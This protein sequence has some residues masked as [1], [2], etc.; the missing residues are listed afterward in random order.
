MRVNRLTCEFL[1]NPIAIDAKQPRLGWILTSEPKSHE[2]NKAQSAYKVLVASTIE[3]LT[4]EKGDLWDSGKVESAD[5]CHVEY[6]GQD[7]RSRMKCYWKVKVWDEKGAETGWS[8]A[9]CWIMGVL[10]ESDWTETSKWIGAHESFTFEERFPITTE[11]AEVPEAFRAAARRLHPSGEGPENPHAMALYLRKEFMLNQ[12]PTKIEQ[13]IVRIAGLG[14]YELSL[15]GAKV[16]DHVLDPGA[17]DYTKHVFYIAYDVTQ[18]LQKGNNCIGVTLG[19]GWYFV[20]TPDLFGYEK[21]PW[22]APPKCRL[23]LEIISQEGKRQILGTDETWEC[24]EEG[25]IRFN[26]IR[27]GEVYDARKDLGA[28]DTPSGIAQKGKPWENVRIVSKPQG[29][30]RVQMCPPIKVERAI[31]PSKHVEPESGI[32]VYHFPENVAGWVQIKVNGQSGQT[33][34]L[35]LNEK[36][37]EDGLVDIFTHSGHTFGRFQTCEYICKGGGTETWHPRFCYQGFQFVQVEGAKLDEIVDIEAQVVHTA[38]TR[39]GHFTCSNSLINQIDEIS[40]RTFLNGFHSY[41]EDCPQREKAGWTED[42]TLSAQGSMYNFDCLGIYEKWARDLLDA[43]EGNGQ[44]PDIVPCPGWGRPSHSHNA[45]DVGNM[46]DPWWGGAI[47]HLPWTIY[48]HYGD[49][50]LLRDC[51]PAMK[52]YVKFLDST[53]KG[54]K[55]IRWKTLLGDWLEVGAGSSANRTPKE[56]TATQAFY[57]YTSII[58]KAAAILGAKESEKEFTVLAEKIAASCNKQFLDNNTGLYCED[59]QSAPAISLF[60][61]LAP[62]QL[63][64]KIFDQLVQN[65]ESKWK[66]HLSTGIVGSYF[67]YQA[68]S[69]EG[70]PEIAYDAIVAKGFPGFEHMLNFH[71]NKQ[72]PTTTLWEDWPGLSSLCHPVQGCVVSYFY[73]FLAGIRPEIEQPGFKRFEI[74]PNIVRDLSEAAA[75]VESLYGTIRSEWKRENNTLHL[76]VEVPLNTSALVI[77]PGSDPSAVQEESNP[78][79]NCAGVSQI[80]VIK[81]TIRFNA[82][83]GVYDFCIPFNNILVKKISKKVKRT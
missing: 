24:S 29:E 78:L 35:K 52:R 28:W 82:G 22:A 72:A 38:V 17:T 19:G 37:L 73:E 44:V 66:G 40:R 43:Q 53:T 56:L 60:T 48:R 67:L 64:A 61:G 80:E 4:A 11:I 13:A 65:V 18:N 54:D 55:I 14:Y 39:A 81:N 25:P 69:R 42:G 77:L 26:C 75:R 83:S 15:N 76:N 58:A 71:S 33:I 63:R 9:A 70:T 31:K 74:A 45:P 20:G 10:A 50:A 23:E 36:L 47:V 30:L 1:V 79:A 12:S 8:E 59:S 57:Y 51:F 7:L 34:T 16:G 21:A 49:I 5:S 2:R 41:P 3:N 46:A 32:L 6:A 27:S 62:P 68:L